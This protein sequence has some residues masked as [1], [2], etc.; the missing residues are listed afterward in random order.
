METESTISKNN[1][2]IILF[3]LMC[4]LMQKRNSTTSCLRHGERGKGQRQNS[5]ATIVAV[6]TLLDVLVQT[7]VCGT[8]SH[9]QGN[10]FWRFLNSILQ[11]HTL[12]TAMKWP[13][14]VFYYDSFLR[15][16]NYHHILRQRFCTTFLQSEVWHIWISH[17]TRDKSILV[18]LC[19]GNTLKKE[20]VLWVC[21]ENRNDFLEFF[22]LMFPCS[23]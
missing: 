17:C 19:K 2:R 12:V 10:S 18:F 22:I 6:M 1:Y 5:N 11:C 4:K 16:R 3:L 14:H 8:C 13:L 20:Q 21:K 23:C 15:I 7:M 9:N